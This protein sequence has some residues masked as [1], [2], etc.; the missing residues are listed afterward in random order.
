MDMLPRCNLTYEDTAPGKSCCLG[1]NEV[2]PRCN[3]FH[4][5][6]L[7]AEELRLSA[8]VFHQQQTITAEALP[9]MIARQTG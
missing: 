6:A 7:Q 8:C 2:S 9:L 4:L 5:M 3:H 1:Q